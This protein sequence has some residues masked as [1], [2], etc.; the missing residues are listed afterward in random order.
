MGSLRGG[1]H[2]ELVHVVLAQ[3]DRAGAE[4]LFRHAGVV[5]GEEVAQDPAPAGGA[6]AAG[7]EDVL[8]PYGYAVERAAE[9][10]LRLLL[11]ARRGLRRGRFR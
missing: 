8:E 11:V 5:G 10:P 9:S 7:A 6:H 1:T 4:D 2:R 3:Q